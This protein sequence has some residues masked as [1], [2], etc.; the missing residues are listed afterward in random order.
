MGVRRAAVL[1]LLFISVAPVRASLSIGHGRVAQRFRMPGGQEARV[2]R[3][4]QRW[5]DA[6]LDH[7]SWTPGQQG[8]RQRYFVCESERWQP[9]APIFFYAGNEANVELYVAR[10]PPNHRHAEINRS[11]RETSHCPSEHVAGP[12]SSERRV[13]GASEGQRR[14]AVG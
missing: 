6:T 9:G 4:S 12:P 5:Y 10:P 2:E 1:M 11:P 7:F 8:W 3:C 13:G 14:A